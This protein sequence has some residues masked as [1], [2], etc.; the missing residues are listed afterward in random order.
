MYWDYIQVLYSFKAYC[1]DDVCVCFMKDSKEDGFISR[2]EALPIIFNDIV[3]DLI[4]WMREI[5]RITWFN[6]V[7]YKILKGIRWRK[8][9]KQWLLQKKLLKRLQ[10]TS[11]EGV[12]KRAEQQEVDDAAKV[13]EVLVDLHISG[14][15]NETEEQDVS[16]IESNATEANKLVQTSQL[17]PASKQIDTSNEATSL[18]KELLDVIV[19]FS[20]NSDVALSSLTGNHVQ[21][22]LNLDLTKQKEET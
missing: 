4:R 5:S 6:S 13:I 9:I 1:F 22:K 12:S 7:K 21:E 10:R 18:R 3:Y 16:F 15:L 20:S 14:A 17:E 2:L 8:P 19:V 11:W